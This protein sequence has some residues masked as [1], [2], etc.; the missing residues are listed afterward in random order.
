[1]RPVLWLWA[2]LKLFQWEKPCCAC[3][4]SA[5]KWRGLEL[6]HQNRFLC[7]YCHEPGY[8][9][10]TKWLLKSNTQCRIFRIIAPCPPHPA[11]AV[12]CARRLPCWQCCCPVG[13][14]ICCSSTFTCDCGLFPAPEEAP[15]PNYGRQVHV[16]AMQGLAIPSSISYTRRTWVF[17]EPLSW[18]VVLTEKEIETLDCFHFLNIAF[19]SEGFTL[20]E[21]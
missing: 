6:R 17:N 2:Q 10:V 12:G 4:F 14:P 7:T 19:N 16:K 8:T 1:M 20:K 13:A 3:A 21:T 18:S 11:Q 15:V 9:Y 5:L